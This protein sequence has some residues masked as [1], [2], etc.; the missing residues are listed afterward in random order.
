[1]TTYR[2]NYNNLLA[3]AKTIRSS[4]MNEDDD[5]AGEDEEEDLGEEESDDEEN[6]NMKR[7]KMNPE[8]NLEKNI[9]KVD[10]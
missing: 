8:V 5:D 7:I 10:I 2:K 9:L 1:M 4:E 3:N 6:S